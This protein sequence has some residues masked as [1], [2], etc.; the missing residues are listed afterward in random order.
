MRETPIALHKATSYKASATSHEFEI[1][2]F[3]LDDIS[4]RLHNPCYVTRITR[5]VMVTGDSKETA[6]AIAR[7]FGIFGDNDS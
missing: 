7:R 5:H 1:L 2:V 6:F 3:W 4:E